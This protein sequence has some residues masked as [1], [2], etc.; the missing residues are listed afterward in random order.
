MRENR[1]VAQEAEA[2][3]DVRVRI[4]EWEQGWR[5]RISKPSSRIEKK[6]RTF[7]KLDLAGVLGEVG[8]NGQGEVLGCH[9]PEIG[10][11]PVRARYRE[12]WCQDRLHQEIGRAHV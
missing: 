5:I 7:R 1:V 9:V 6:A 8:L 11:D 12:S 10:Q 2:L 4:R 3:V